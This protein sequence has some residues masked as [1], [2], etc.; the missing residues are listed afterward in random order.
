MTE[1]EWLACVDPTPMFPYLKGD[2]RGRLFAVACCRRV[3]R[4]LPDVRT[5]QVVEVAERYADEGGDWAGLL[6][7]L[8]APLVS[9]VRDSGLDIATIPPAAKLAVG[10]VRPQATWTG[11]AAQAAVLVFEAANDRH[12][13]LRAP[14]GQEVLAA[15]TAWSSA[16]QARD[17]ERAA[18]AA[19]VRDL[20]GNPFRHVS[21]VPSWLR[22]DDGCLGKVARA[23]YEERAFD[24]MPILADAL[25][26]AGCDNADLLGHLRG[27]GS[28]VR[29]CW[30]LDLILGK[31]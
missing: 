5:R 19:V 10:L 21:V 6:E 20:V 29:G 7:K 15:R 23:I 27:P 1:A 28:H 14:I 18:Q 25:E 31:S 12:A 2:R 22:W 30:A 26:D 13:A 17:A 4:L 11:F 9:A 24:R 16:T 3:W 8:L